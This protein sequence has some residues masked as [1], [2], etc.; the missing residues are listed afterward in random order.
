[1]TNTNH[2][3]LAKRVSEGVLLLREALPE[4]MKAFGGLA[5]AATATNALDTK[6]KELMALAIG[7]AIQ[8]DGCVAIHA[9]LA[10]R[11]GASRQEVAETIALAIYMGGGPASVY[12]AE[13]LRAYDEFNAPVREQEPAS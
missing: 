8:C 5:A 4:P 7:V 9:K 2:V 11:H 3:E 10:Q 12:G 6:I 1:M 13:A